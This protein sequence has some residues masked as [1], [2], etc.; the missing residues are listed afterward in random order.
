L[1]NVAMEI[2]VA[3][4]HS[5]NFDTGFAIQVALLH[6]VLE[7]TAVTA[8]GLKMDFGIEVTTGVQALTRNKRLPIQEQ[9]N[10]C[11]QRLKTCVPEVRAVK[12]ADRITNL[13]IPPLSWTTEKKQN[14]LREGELILKELRGTNEY[15]EQRLE[16]KIEEYSGYVINSKF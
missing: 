12:L 5:K 2:L 4:S 8:K 1:S 7:D 16:L 6:D 9:M 11:L 10:D 13:Q 14:Y 3:A 15:L